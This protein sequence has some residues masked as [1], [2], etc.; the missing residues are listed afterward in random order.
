MTL[1]NGYNT[2][3]NKQQDQ[4]NRLESLEC[5]I[6]KIQEA[7]ETLVAAVYETDTADHDFM[8]GEDMGQ[9]MNG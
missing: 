4:S 7:L 9:V 5:K 6:S 1:L 8:L 2:R 3:N